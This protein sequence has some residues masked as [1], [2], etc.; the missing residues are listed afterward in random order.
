VRYIRNANN[1][2][3]DRTGAVLPPFRETGGR[4]RFTLLAAQYARTIGLPVPRRMPSL[5]QLP[6]PR[7]PRRLRSQSQVRTGARTALESCATSLLPPCTR[8]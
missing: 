4:I 7:W 5:R 1:R 3:T 2:A 8:T 6:A